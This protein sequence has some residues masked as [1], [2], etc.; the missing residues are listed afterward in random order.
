MATVQP[1]PPGAG[2]AFPAPVTRAIQHIGRA[3]PG[4][5][6]DGEHESDG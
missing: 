2:R 3:S 6:A 1:K 4:K 5:K